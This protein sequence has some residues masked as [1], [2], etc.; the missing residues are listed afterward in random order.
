MTSSHAP[1][2]AYEPKQ[3]K[4]RSQFRVWI[5]ENTRFRDTDAQGHVNNAVYAT[6]FEIARGATRHLLTGRPQG[7]TSVVAR[8]VIN[9]H[10]QLRH[11]AKLDI[12]TA[13]VRIGRSSWDL[14][15]GLFK[16][17]VCHATGEVTM[18][19]IEKATG[20]SMPLP[21]AFRDKLEALMLGRH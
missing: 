8:Q 14:G 12:G 20:R 10:V 3:L 13:V 17:E 9:Y 4:D 5:S 7:S 21:A 16:E 1:A 15:Y 19:L 2:H 18:V 11:P 6:Y